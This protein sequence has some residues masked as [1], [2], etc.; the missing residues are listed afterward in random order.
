M[1]SVQPLVEVPQH[2]QKGWETIMTTPLETVNFRLQS[3][4]HLDPNTQATA[5]DEYRKFLGL[6]L[7][8][9]GGFAM[10]SPEVDEVWHTHILFTQDYSQF[11]NAVF[12]HYL[13]HVPNTPMTPSRPG[14]V[15]R[16]F[17]AYRKV[18]GK[19]NSIWPSTENMACKSICG[20]CGD[21]NDYQCSME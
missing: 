15:A 11:C 5:V 17:G 10:T 3:E 13:H 12:G 20:D 2:L 7:L 6:I 8:E 16:F 4:G 9:N 21:C 18:F 19:L 1:E 14:G